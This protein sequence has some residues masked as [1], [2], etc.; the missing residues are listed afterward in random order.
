MASIHRR[1]G[2]TLEIISPWSLSGAAFDLTQGDGWGV[3]AQVRDK[4]TGTILYQMQ[5]DRTDAADG[6]IVL[7]AAP[8]VTAYWSPGAYEVNIALVAPNGYRRT[9]EI[10]D[11]IILREVTR[12]VG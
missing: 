5:E 4:S 2:E 6:V 8:D 1:S 12:H 7:T 11:L 10:K 3:S 9:T